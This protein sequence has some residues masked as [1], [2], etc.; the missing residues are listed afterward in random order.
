MV[1]AVVGEYGGIKEK[2]PAWERVAQ[3]ALGMS[4][5]HLWLQ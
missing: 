5:P 1:V 2:K 4:P 3:K